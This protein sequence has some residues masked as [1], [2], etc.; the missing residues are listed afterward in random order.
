MAKQPQQMV[1]TRVT[2]VR[3]GYGQVIVEVGYTDTRYL[4]INGSIES[5]RNTDTL[6][7]SCGAVW[8]PV[9]LLAKPPRFIGIC[10]QCRD[11][12]FR[13]WGMERATHG[14]VLMS[15]AKLCTCGT[16]CCPR[17]RSMCADGKWRCMAC[18]KRFRRRGWLT[19]LFWKKVR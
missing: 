4:G 13:A 7:T 9:Q 5:R 2:T 15:N 12:P 8:S 17:H 16:L 19:W 3:D 1:D 18:A 14:I 11:P 6:T 10:D